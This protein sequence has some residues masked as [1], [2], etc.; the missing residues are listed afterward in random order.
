MRRD[1]A[2]DRAIEIAGKSMLFLTTT[3][4][5]GVPHLAAANSID[6][7]EAGRITVT[8]WFCPQTLANAVIGRPVSVVVWDSGNDEGHQLIGYV[9][10]LEERAVVNGYL[11]NEDENVPPPQQEFQL[12][13]EV[14]KVMAFHKAPHSDLEE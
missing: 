4:G 11:P 14:S 1:K 10:A 13:I 7:P 3:D 12:L 8:D 2:I 6:K 5:K 9:A